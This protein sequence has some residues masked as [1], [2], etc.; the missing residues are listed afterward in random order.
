MFKAFIE[1]VALFAVLAAVLGA[2]RAWT[3]DAHEATVRF[4][5]ALSPHGTWLE[6]PG[7]GTVWKPNPS[8][9]GTDFYPY[10]TGGKW[11]LTEYGWTWKSQWKWGWIP[12]H[13][14]QWVETIDHGW[15]WVP[16]DVWAPAW[17]EW[18]VGDGF[19]GW[20]PTAPSVYA[21]WTAS[22]DPRWA[23]MQ[24]QDLAAPD[25]ARQRI[26]DPR[27]E[28]RL[29]RDIIS[30]PPDA[31]ERP[32]G[33][34]PRVLGPIARRIEQAELGPPRQLGEGAARA[35]ERVRPPSAR[36]PSPGEPPSD[37]Q[38]LAPGAP[39]T[40]PSRELNPAFRD[41]FERFEQFP[42][43]TPSGPD[44]GFPRERDVLPQERDVFP[45]EREVLPRER[46]DVFPREREVFP[47]P[48]A[49][50]QERDVLPPARDAFP[51]EPDLVPPQQ[52]PQGPDE[53]VPGPP[54]AP[55]DTGGTR[56]FGVPRL[57]GQP[58]P[59]I[60]PATERGEVLPPAGPTGEAP[61][62]P[63]PGQTPMPTVVPGL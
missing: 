19:V 49:F 38:G 28:R 31:R 35:E 18:K 8:V 42:L 25:L 12:F 33:P 40:P 7:L 17:V 51:G 44:D 56:S 2:G 48:E 22:Y 21:N 37:A 43:R 39:P 20:V 3:Q 62:L 59:Q 11:Q 61:V 23:W 26:N 14:G 16:D 30:V 24:L 60:P 36:P 50:P 41:G 54:P 29:E 55:S 57:P 9:V 53:A 13:H 27:L 46:D 58:P 47:R 34:S 4:Y 10:L 5:D 15:V 45:R 1:K 6:K 32:R 63:A 52:A